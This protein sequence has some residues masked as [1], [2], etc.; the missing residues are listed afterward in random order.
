MA[1]AHAF[2]HPGLAHHLH[3]HSCSIPVY[4]T[5]LWGIMQLA[6]WSPCPWQ[7][8]WQPELLHHPAILDHDD[9]LELLPA[10]GFPCS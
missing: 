9:W 1:E 7:T 5:L 3:R 10:C 4:E 8:F 6:S 2:R